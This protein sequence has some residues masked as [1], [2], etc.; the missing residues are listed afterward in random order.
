MGI[1][2]GTISNFN[3]NHGYISF[4]TNEFLHVGDK[5]CVENKKHETNLYTI[6]ELMKMI[7]T[8]QKHILV[9]K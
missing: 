3:K 2:L 8:L 5:I 7:K 9:I 1:Y 4:T 6:S